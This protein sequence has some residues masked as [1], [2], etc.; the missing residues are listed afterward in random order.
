[1]IARRIAAETGGSLV[2]LACLLADRNRNQDGE[3]QNF[4]RYIVRDQEGVEGKRA[5]CMNIVVL[6]VWWWP[7]GGGSVVAMV[8]GVIARS[9]PK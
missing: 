3:I 2:L 6:L 4:G 9:K 5:E 1:M 7:F 8:G